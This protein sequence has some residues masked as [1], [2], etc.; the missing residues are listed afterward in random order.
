MRRSVTLLALALMWSV[1]V[2][3]AQTVLDL[4]SYFSGAVGTQAQAGVSAPVDLLFGSDSYIPPFYRG[5]PLPSPGSR[6]H[7]WAYAHFVDS[8]GAAIPESSITYTW[9][10]NGQVEGSLSGVGKSSLALPSPTLFGTDTISV[11]AGAEDGAIYGSASLTISSVD[12]G[13]TLYQDHPLHGI[14]YYS[15]LGS[16][17]SIPDLEMTFA[18]VPYFVAARSSDDPQ[19]HFAWSVNGVSVAATS[20][21]ANEITVN[22]D[23]SNGLAAISLLIT[24]PV[25]ALLEAQSAWNFLFSR[26]RIPIR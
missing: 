9:R 5:A 22:A 18:A 17:T 20:T 4:G 11:D 2:A 1:S 19:L 13:V 15:A 23:N 14:E 12:P 24:S 16:Q 21:N 8:R 10:R 26:T 25:N 7:F 3:R 6:V